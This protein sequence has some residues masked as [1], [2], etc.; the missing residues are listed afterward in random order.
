MVDELHC[1]V[2]EVECH[3]FVAHNALDQDLEPA[4]MQPFLYSPQTP[5]GSLI[6]AAFLESGCCP[7]VSHQYTTVT[8]NPKMWFYHCVYLLRYR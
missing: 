7:I 4:A 3:R 6:R 8:E 1:L 5:L 2:I